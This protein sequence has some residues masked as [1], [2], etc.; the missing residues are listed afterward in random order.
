MFF[1]C[2]AI[3]ALLEFSNAH[4]LDELTY[5]QS[6]TIIQFEIVLVLGAIAFSSRSMRERSVL[7]IVFLWAIW[8]FATDQV[9]YFP[10]IV[11]SI[12]TFI[13][14][15]FI[16]WAWFRPYNYVSNPPNYGTV[17]LAFYGGPNAP[18]LSRIAANFGFP[19]SSIALVAGDLAVR[20]SKARGEMVLISPSLLEAK[21]YVFV[22]TGCKVTPAI[23]LELE[24]VIG[25]PTAYGWF[26]VKCLQNL[27]PV[28]RTLGDEWTPDKNWP[29][30]P[31]FY[32][33]KCLEN[34]NER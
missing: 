26:R 7:D 22:D 34:Q 5:I 2:V 20:P 13:F 6:F 17:V 19:F 14:F 9:D 8:I 30:I 21:G 23:I 31:S 18:F 11:A 27:M 32:Y 10:P 25:T 24:K 28:L 4:L 3:L 1:L 33:R 29:A 12:E 15:S 16:S